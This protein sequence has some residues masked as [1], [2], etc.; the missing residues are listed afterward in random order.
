MAA[1]HQRIRRRDQFLVSFGEMQGSRCFDV[2]EFKREWRIWILPREVRD[3]DYIEDC[4][5]F[6]RN[7]QRRYDFPIIGRGSG[8][9]GENPEISAETKSEGGNERVL[10]ELAKSEGECIPNSD[11]VSE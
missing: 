11:H 2:L 8:E 5:E 9:A 1:D 4:Q 7:R 6:V 10:G 3:N